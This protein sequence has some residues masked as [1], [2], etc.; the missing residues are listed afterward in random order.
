MN[1][2]FTAITNNNASYWVIFLYGIMT[3]FHCI[4]MCGGFILSGSI[5]IH[6]EK[7]KNIKTGLLYNVGRIISYTTVGAIAGGVGSIVVLSGVLKGALPFIAG[8]LM[9]IMGLNFLGV[10]K[11][12]KINFSLQKI[13][14]NKIFENK[15]KNMFLVGLMSGLLPCGPM[16][17]V[18]I[19][20]LATASVLKGSL[21]MF[22]FAIGTVPV[23]F[24]FGYFSSIL[25][26]KFTKIVL[27]LSAV[28]LIIMGLLM[29]CRGLTLW[30]VKIDASKLWS[31]NTDA[32]TAT[33]RDDEQVLITEF[34]DEKF[35]NVAFKEGI[36]VK[37]IINVDKKYVGECTATIMI[38]E[39]GVKVEL[40]EGENIIKFTPKEARNVT[41]SSWCGMLSGVITIYE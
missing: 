38:E 11:K 17:A 34:T 15:S 6:S 25:N 23:L 35:Y 8:I 5:S 37:W 2:D 22:V 28:V 36:P 21:V 9:I 4:S 31:Q 20:S 19:Y 41:Y 24:L 40:N 13:F 39:Y 10:L 7:G 33:V 29:V 14:G 26:V 30:G 16:Q 3:S 32:I 12:I 1:M 27:K 18:Q